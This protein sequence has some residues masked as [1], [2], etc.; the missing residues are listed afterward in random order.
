MPDAPIGFDD[1]TPPDGFQGMSPSGAVAPASVSFHPSP[2]AQNPRFSSHIG[3]YHENGTYTSAAS[4]SLR[5]SVMPAC[6]YRSFAQSLPACGLI[7]SRRANIVGSL[8]IAM[9]WIHATAP[10]DASATLS[11]P[12]TIAIA[13]S[14]D[15]HTSRYRSGSQSR[16]DSSTVFK[17]MSGRWRCAFGFRNAARRSFTATKWPMW[18]GAPDRYMY[19]RIS[20]AK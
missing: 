5:G 6:A 12:I 19:A 11:L 9:P 17:S 15:G 18:R 10:S 3:S 13:P 16:N 1:S 14:D 7:W 2:S 20:G 4:N 8:R